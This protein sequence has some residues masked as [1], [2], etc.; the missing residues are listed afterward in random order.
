MRV[1]VEKRRRTCRTQRATQ[2]AVTTGLLLAGS[3][4][5]SL[6]ADPIAGQQIFK[7]QCGICHATMWAPRSITGSRTTDA[8]FGPQ[9]ECWSTR[10]HVSLTELNGK[11]AEVKARGRRQRTTRLVESAKTNKGG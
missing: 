8:G 1:V 5:A 6:A 7:V 4:T 2:R 3:A 11:I 9:R 10:N